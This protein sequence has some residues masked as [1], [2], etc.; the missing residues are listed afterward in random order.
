MQMKL[1]LDGKGDHDV[2]ITEQYYMYRLAYHLMKHDTYEVLHVN[3]KTNEVL[4]GKFD[5]K[6]TNVVRLI[7]KGFDWKNHMKVDIATLFQRVKSMDRFLLG[8]NVDIY[9]VYVTSHEPVDAWEHYKRP[10][11]VDN[12]AGLRMHVFYMIEETRQAE[13]E[14]LF[15]HIGTESFIDMALPDEEDQELAVTEYKLALR[16]HLHR[17]NEEIKGVF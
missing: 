7:H 2:Y 14:R 9:N 11:H 3:P 10:I 17:R 4:L 1:C 13:K 8:K 15:S 12:K 6:K 16:N 5:R